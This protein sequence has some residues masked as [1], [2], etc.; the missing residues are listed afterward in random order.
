MRA[1]KSKKDKNTPAAA[2]LVE[3]DGTAIKKIASESHPKPARVVKSVPFSPLSAP[4]NHR[5]LADLAAI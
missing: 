3:P 4:K 2:K 5:K 1:K